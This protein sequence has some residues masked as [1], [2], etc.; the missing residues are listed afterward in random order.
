MGNRTVSATDF[1]TSRIKIQFTSRSS[2]F[3]LTAKVILCVRVFFFHVSL[4][5]RALSYAGT[6]P[7]EHGVI[8]VTTGVGHELLLIVVRTKSRRLRVSA[9]R[10]LQNRHSRIAKLFADGFNFRRD[11]AQVFRDDRQRAESIREDLKKFTRLGL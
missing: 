5:A 1:M 3:A 4:G 2:S 9:E 6:P 11:Y 10:K 7:S 8:V